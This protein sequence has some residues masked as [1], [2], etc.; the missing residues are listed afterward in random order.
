MT[1]FKAVDDLTVEITLAS[2]NADL[3][4]ILA[5]HHFMILADGTTDFSKANGTGAFV[6]EVFEPGVRSLATKNK[7]YW[8]Q[9]GPHLDSFEFFAISDDSAR[10][11]ALISGDIQL[12]AS[13]NPRSMRLLETQPSVAISKT[14]SGNY[15]NLNM[16][17][18][19][20]PGNKA[21]FVTGM[22]YLL[23][24]QQIQKSVLRGL[25]EIGN[26]QPISRPASITTPI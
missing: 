15:T 14:T 2:P 21:D 9:G 18:D 19:M 22:K 6:C 25:A 1:G 7:N 26:D 10:V 12:A 20:S 16:R 17:L 23:N 24:R 11:N 13:I 5:M 8:K 3:P 4:T